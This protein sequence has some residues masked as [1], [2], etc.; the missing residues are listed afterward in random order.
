M[1][2]TYV[3]NVHVRGTQEIV[4][5]ANTPEEAIDY[6]ER[7]AND[8]AWQVEEE[9]NVHYGDMD[10]FYIHHAD[11]TIDRECLLSELTQGSDT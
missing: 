6:L 3:F 11:N 7:L 10:N 4:I 1:G 8:R 5:R 2:D 9:V